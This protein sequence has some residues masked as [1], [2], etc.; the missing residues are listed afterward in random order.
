MSEREART[1]QEVGEAAEEAAEYFR[2]LQIRG[3]QVTAAVVMTQTYIQARESP[4]M[5]VVV[6]PDDEEEGDPWR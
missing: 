5:V 3:V 1:T 4:R 6:D 2:Q